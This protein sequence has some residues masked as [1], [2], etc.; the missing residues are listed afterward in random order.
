MSWNDELIKSAEQG[1]LAKVKECL[2]NGA[3]V[4][5]DDGR[6]L[7]YASNNGHFEIVK[8]LVKNGAD[9]KNSGALRGASEYGHFEMVKYL[10][11]NGANMN[12]GLSGASRNG[13]FEIVKYLVENG[14]DV[15]NSGALRGAS[16]YGHFEIVKYL[17]ANGANVNVGNCG[18]T[19]IDV[20]KNDEI[21]T[22]LE[23]NKN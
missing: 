19:A 12:N 4:N 1:N 16:E 3:D 9:V 18:K 23:K 21:R 17:V 14:A 10:V 11:E 20:A 13:H 5:A 2:A 22:F 6:A 15:K 7:R 8:Y